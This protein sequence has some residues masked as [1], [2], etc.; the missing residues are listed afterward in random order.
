M[1]RPCRWSDAF[2]GPENALSSSE[3]RSVVPSPAVMSSDA[4]ARCSRMA[5]VN[6]F[7]QSVTECRV[8]DVEFI[9]KDFSAHLRSTAPAAS[10]LWAPLS[11]P[12][13]PRPWEN[14]GAMK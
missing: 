10:D 5:E 8:S 2:R 7:C 13:S 14:A 4:M 3:P 6:I 9:F 1:P 11:I 12:R